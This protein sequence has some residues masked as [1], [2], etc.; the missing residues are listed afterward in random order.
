MLTIY[1]K[2]KDEYAEAFCKMF[3]SR[4]VK[5]KRYLF[6][7]NTIAQKIAEYVN[8]DGFINTVSNEDSF[9]N[10]P[11]IQ[12]LDD[13]PEDSLVINCVLLSVVSVQYKLLGYSWRSIDC[14]RFIT[15]V[16]LPI[17][18][19]HFTGWRNDI[20]HNIEEYK[21]IYNLLSDKSSKNIF[22]K[23]IN[24]KVTADIHYL[25]GFNTDIEGQ[26][27]D[28]CLSL[29]S[30][31]VFCDV[32][33]FDGFTTKRFVTLYPNYGKVYFFEPEDNNMHI[34]KSNLELYDNIVFIQKGCGSVE[35]HLNFYADADRSVITETGNHIIEIDRLDCLVDGKV[36]FIKMDIEGAE[37]E[38]L[39]GASDTIKKYHPNIAISV[40]HKPS[41]FWKIP[42]QIL[43]IRTRLQ[44][45][46]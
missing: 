44:H 6:G 9:M 29:P 28:N 8:V 38:A 26:Y 21:Q 15:E 20:E 11:M 14:Y 41:D 16:N 25:Y 10:K 27:F 13:L 36:D 43:N 40:Y 22:A 32:G 12:S 45:R 17:D 34:A 4:D 30:N 39:V 46:S 31:P 23:M 19:F 3:M 35:Q 42:K 7:T 33:G 2:Y 18:I 37:E 24:F 5:Y 1:P